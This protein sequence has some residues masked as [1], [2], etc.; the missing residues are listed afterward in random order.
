MRIGVSGTPGT[1]KTTLCRAISAATG[2]VH[3]DITSLAKEKGWILSQDEGRDT[4]IVDVEKARRHCDARKD[5]LI[6]S[7]F[8]E[9]LGPDIMIVMRTD[10]AD[11]R[12]RLEAR[13]YAPEKIR[14]NVLAEMLDTCLI[15]A[16]EQCGDTRVFEIVS[17]DGYDCADYA[18][19]LINDP[20]EMKSVAYK[21]TVRYL[22]EENLAFLDTI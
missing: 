21:R 6:D 5:A 19:S 14:E 2:L 18:I 11:L 1:G 12:T 10:P 4:G 22:T 9:L 8:A 16:V 15:A 20:D 7:H 13:G 3:L 17:E